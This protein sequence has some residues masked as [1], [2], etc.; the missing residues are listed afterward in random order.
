M[1]TAEY[2]FD[3]GI[4]VTDKI[5]DVTTVIESLQAVSL[6]GS[7]SYY[8]KLK[9]V[10][11]DQKQDINKLLAMLH[12]AS[13]LFEEKTN[14]ETFDGYSATIFRDGETANSLIKKGYH[15]AIGT[16][17]REEVFSLILDPPAPSI[18]PI[19]FKFD[20]SKSIAKTNINLLIGE[21]GAGKSH[22][23]KKLS[24]VMLGITPNKSAWPFFHK[25]IVAAYS[26]FESFYTKEQILDLIDNKKNKSKNRKKTKE[27]KAQRNIQINKYAY[28]GF[29]NNNNEFNLNWPKI[30]SV[31]SVKSIMEY[32]KEENWWTE[33]TRLKILK[34]TL[35]LSMDF[36]SIA[37]KL[38]SSN[39]FKII[40]DGFY[41]AFD[42]YKED[43][44]DQ[45]GLFFLK[46]G[47][48]ITLSSGQEVFSYMIPSLVSEIEDESL[49]IIDEP[50]LYLHPTLEVG[51]INMLKRL[52]SE[53][54]SS[55][56]IATHSALIAREVA[57]DGIIILKK[58]DGY[59]SVNNPEIQTYGESLEVIIGEAFDDFDTV[60]PFQ[61]E[62]DILMSEP[63]KLNKIIDGIFEDIGDE[64]LAYIKSSS[65][66]NSKVE[67][68]RK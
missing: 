22:I 29:K 54:N 4:S 51:L 37:V 41:N 30:F 18:D 3:K 19:E 2:L 63:V 40:E 13:Y 15:V 35:S 43:I 66:N 21:N 65:F 50:E 68:E 48:P 56:I 67:F 60:K 1:N 42:Q 5:I 31:N 36:E 59:T 8:Q 44:D 11:E 20:I 45:Q 28:V 47:D 52:L 9:V 55:A 24:E 6:G 26:P 53:T 25:L 23:L 34:D 27:Y 49:I 62:I 33:N 64:A 57:K 46:D 12:D 16:Y 14:Y 58:N 7:I 10:L 38:K 32:D 39:E 17:E 61:N